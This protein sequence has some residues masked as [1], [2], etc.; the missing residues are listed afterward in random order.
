MKL[1]ATYLLATR[2][3]SEENWYTLNA[4]IFGSQFILDAPNLSISQ[5]QAWAEN[6]MRVK[7]LQAAY[8]NEILLQADV[9]RNNTL[10]SYQSLQGRLFTST[11]TN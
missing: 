3:N 7:Q 2:Y 11:T 1:G 4:S 6:D 10:N 9:E 5:L 8:P